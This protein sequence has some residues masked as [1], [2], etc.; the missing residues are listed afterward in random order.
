MNKKIRVSWR[1]KDKRIFGAFKWN[2]Y[3]MAMY[4]D[5]FE[6]IKAEHSWEAQYGSKY[7]LK[8]DENW[9]ND[10]KPA[11]IEEFINRNKQLY[12]IFTRG[13]SSCDLFIADITN[14]NPNVLLELGIAIQM[15]KNILVVTGQD[16]DDMPFDIRGYE[17]KKYNS[18]TEL[19]DI[20]VKEI[21]IFDMIKNQNFGPGKFIESKKYLPNQNGTLIDKQVI[22]IGNIPKL[23]NLR[24]KLDFR[25]EYS[26]NHKY[27]WFGV[28]LR[29][30]RNSGFF[31]ELALIR[32]SGKSRS[33]TWPEQRKEE[34]G[35]VF[36]SY[37]P[38]KWCS[39]EILIDENKLSMWI[40]QQLVLED[41]NLLIE[42]FGEIFIRTN[43]HHDAGHFGNVGEGKKNDNGNF[44][45][46]EYR[47]IEILDLS[48]T[49]NLF[50]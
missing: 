37:D 29:S 25:F 26:T 41:Q 8:V 50:E 43:D 5:I 40:H 49:S 17:A 2:A 32:Y 46:V 9:K 7:S 19:Y 23:K 31:S 1:E 13:I 45:E 47:N 27:D 12:E 18:K 34:D 44:L 4:E 33:V 10:I 15:D 22:K 21:K 42:N 16:I 28:H 35:K 20:I 38:N 11:E 14:H 39:M 36:E 30:Q 3:V 6:K 24:I 48:T